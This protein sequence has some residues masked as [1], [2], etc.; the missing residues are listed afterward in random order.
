MTANPNEY[1][2]HEPNSIIAHGTDTRDWQQQALQ[3]A[4]AGLPVFPAQPNKTPYVKGWEQA[5]VTD[6]EQ[7]ATWWSVDYPDALPAVPVGRAGLVVVDLDQHKEGQDGKAALA[8]A[9][10]T[11]PAPPTQWNRSLSGKGEHHYYRVPEG[12]KGRN[13]SNVDRLNGVDLR[14]HGGYVIWPGAPL[15]AAE[16]AN[17]PLAEEWMLRPAIEAPNGDGYSGT[18]SEWLQRTAHLQPD[19]AASGHVAKYVGQEFGNSELY[20]ALGALVAIGAQG[21]NVAPALNEL[22]REWLRPPKYDTPELAR[23]FDDQLA[24]LITE[25]GAPQQAPTSLFAPGYKSPAGQPVT[26]GTNTTNTDPAS[27]GSNGSGGTGDETATSDELD[28]GFWDTRPELATI[29]NTARARITGP[30]AVLGCVLANI[31]L[32]IPYGRTLPGIVGGPAALNLMV[33][34]VG[35]SGSGKGAAEAVAKEL[36]P[37]PESVFDLPPGSGEGM[38]RAFG[39]YTTSDG[40]TELEWSNPAHAARFTASEVTGLEQLTSR[41]G[42]TLSDQ[43]LKLYSGETLGFQNANILTRNIIPAKEYRAALTVGVQPPHAGALLNHQ[44]AGLPQRFL[45]M[46]TRDPAAS[47]DHATASRRNLIAPIDFYRFPLHQ[48]SGPL[49]V[50]D[51]V[52][53][54]L[55]NAH[56]Q[57]VRDGGGD[58]DAH[59]RLTRL[60][61]AA[62]LAVLNGRDRIDQ[63]DWRLAGRVMNVSTATREQC[64]QAI[65]DDARRKSI[66]Q[67]E[68]QALQRQGATDADQRRTDQR[69]RVLD[70]IANRGPLT[71]RE[72]GQL[73]DSQRRSEGQAEADALVGVG[74]LVRDGNRYLLPG[75]V[76]QP[77]VEAVE[78]GDRGGVNREKTGEQETST[79]INKPNLD[80]GDTQNCGNAL[81]TLHTPHVPQSTNSSPEQATDPRSICQVCSN[82][83]ILDRGDGP[84]SKC[85]GVTA[86]PS[87]VT[88]TGTAATG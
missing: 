41:K 83:V 46:P 7:I 9:T 25:H 2:G 17:L 27:V 87:P 13:G 69:D 23:V 77:P 8:A 34:I 81:H 68:R 32:H 50:P 4:A 10:A 49:H 65:A 54:E 55:V 35:G 78:C 1:D 31:V 75:M 19:D 18:V 33:A 6:P 15:T 42:A 62:A 45:W 20:S 73:F 22:H 64:V 74:R 66:E 48:T 52:R 21:R 39:A 37:Y 84:C 16:R 67:G 71:R 86:I 36:V 28:P 11:H 3:L 60:K 70:A 76:P 14:G 85:A 80:R 38:A 61:V 63:G 44:A 47:A 24:R 51:E 88:D 57:V 59:A 56:V 72:I 43:L 40:V 26:T 53:N 79:R 30:W 29:R 12:R 58:L 5:A 82:P